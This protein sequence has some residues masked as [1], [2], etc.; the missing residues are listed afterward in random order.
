MAH[1]ESI[2]NAAQSTWI[3]KPHR[4]AVMAILRSVQQGLFTA[5]E[6]ELMIGRI[7]AIPTSPDRTVS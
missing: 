6:A 7:R 3:V 1:P 5:A 4:S 2:A